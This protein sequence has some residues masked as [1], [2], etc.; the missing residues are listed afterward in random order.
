MA[1][2]VKKNG[3]EKEGYH[4]FLESLINFKKGKSHMKDLQEIGDIMDTHFLKFTAD[5]T[6]KDAIDALIKQNLFGACIVD[7]EEKLLGI[8]SEKQCI[9]LYSDKIQGNYSKNIND[10]KVSEIMYPE[11]QTMSSHM[12]VIDAAQIFLT[13]DFRRIPV[14]DGGKLVGQ[15]TRRDIMKSIQKL[16]N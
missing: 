15:I 8:V 16:A 6:V 9:K 5:T 2:H 1:I 3:L 10:V 13:S 12:N 14:V 11:F 7:N 4:V